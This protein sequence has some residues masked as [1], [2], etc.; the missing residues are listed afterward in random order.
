M[1]WMMS[2]R[3]VRLGN[4]NNKRLMDAA[5]CFHFTLLLSIWEDPINPSKW[6]E[7]HRKMMDEFEKVKQQLVEYEIMSRPISHKPGLL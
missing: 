7:E 6:K 4:N 3:D 2:K 1:C 5:A